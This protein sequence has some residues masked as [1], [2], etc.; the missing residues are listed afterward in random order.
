MVKLTDD[1]ALMIEHMVENGQLPP[2]AGLRIAQRD[3][4]PALAMRL[5]DG[6]EPE[7]V[8]VTGRQARLFL[9]PVAEAR[10]VGQTLDARSNEAG[11][12]FFVRP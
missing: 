4:H 9:A 11:S 8:T 12:A 1:A 3:D 7:D 5:A 10:L 2:G 6:A